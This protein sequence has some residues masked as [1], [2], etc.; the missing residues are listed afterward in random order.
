[1]SSW[2]GAR[3]L[4]PPHL[5]GDARR[6]GIQAAEHHVH[7]GDRAR[8]RALL[9]D[10]LA[11]APAGSA[12]GMLSAC[13]P[14]SITTRRTCRGAKELFEA[15]LEHTDNQR[16]AA[17][18]EMGL[19][20]VAAGLWDFPGAAAHARGAL[21][22]GTAIGDNALVGEALGYCAMTGLPLRPRGRLECR[23]SSARARRP[24]EDRASPD[25]SQRP[26]RPPPPIRRAAL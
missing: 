19:S 8:G 6:R 9:E 16:L 12:R 10:I 26:C 24:G 20:Y 18:I 13:L 17:T 1:M 15:A 23:R 14:R 5:A 7:A 11:E 25:P 4:T 21:E 2:N 22:L 3:V